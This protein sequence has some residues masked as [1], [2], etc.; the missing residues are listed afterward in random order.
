MYTAFIFLFFIITFAIIKIVKNSP[1]TGT[2][3]PIIRNNPPKNGSTPNYG[4]AA[5]AELQSAH[6]GL[7]RFG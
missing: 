7:T 3:S 1:T 5:R 6:P 2:I 4:L